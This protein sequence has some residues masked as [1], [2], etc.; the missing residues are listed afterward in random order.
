[1][2][3]TITATVVSTRTHIELAF[4]DGPTITDEFDTPSQASSLRITYVNGVATAVAFDSATNLYFMQPSDL[5][6]PENWPTWLRDLVE[7]HRPS[8]DAECPTCGAPVGRACRA[9]NGHSGRPHRA[10]LA[11]PKVHA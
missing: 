11:Q 6:Q 1:M 8:S 2:N 10:R 9:P 3:S 4:T 5:D 7:Q